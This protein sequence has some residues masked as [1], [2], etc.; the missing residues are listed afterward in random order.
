MGRIDRTALKIIL[1]T[2]GLELVA[3]NDIADINNIAYLIK[4]DS[5]HSS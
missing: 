4:Y 5:I 2:P 3:V 1:D